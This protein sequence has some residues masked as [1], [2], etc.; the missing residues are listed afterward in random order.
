MQ[1]V[2]NSE[3]MKKVA[4]ARERYPDYKE[5]ILSIDESRGFRS[6]PIHGCS[7]SCYDPEL[8]LYGTMLPGRFMQEWEHGPGPFYPEPE[9]SLQ[10]DFFECASCQTRFFLQ[11]EDRQFT[12][13][14]VQPE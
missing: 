3:F 13:Q 2:D 8:R 4:L 10:V 6:E 14:L 9:E 7:S 12:V 11:D 1:E 5:A